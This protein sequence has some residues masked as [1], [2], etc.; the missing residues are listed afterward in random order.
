MPDSVDL[1]KAT[2][3]RVVEFDVRFHPLWVTN[4]LQSITL[5]HRDLYWVVI[6]TPNAPERRRIRSSNSHREAYSA[7]ERLDVLLADLCASH[8]IG[9]KVIYDP[10]V[11][12]GGLGK[13]VIEGLYSQAIKRG[14]LDLIDKRMVELGLAPDPLL[15]T[16]VRWSP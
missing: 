13:T 3:L 7:Y 10:R 16:T 12:G 14:M 15:S 4:A 11:W 9:L 2:K 5:D 1:S 8:R 6:H